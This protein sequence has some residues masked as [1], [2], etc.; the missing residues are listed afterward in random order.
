MS[1]I[2]GTE[3]H[4]RKKQGTALPGGPGWTNH[5]RNEG[6]TWP[7]VPEPEMTKLRAAT[8]RFRG[9]TGWEQD[10][11]VEALSAP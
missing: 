8:M 10:Y 6:L 1:S 3:R 5:N 2:L 11:T 7:G 9:K 4:L